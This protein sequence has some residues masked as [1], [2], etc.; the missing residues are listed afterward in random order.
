M[1]HAFAA[2]RGGDHDLAFHGGALYLGFKAPLDGGRAAIWKVADPDKLLAGDAA[3]A[4]IALF[5]HVTLP[6]QMGIADM[7]FV[8]DT[9]LVVSGTT[10]SGSGGVFLVALGKGEPSVTPLQMFP[11]LRPEGVALSPLGKLAVVFDR[12]KSVPLWTELELPHASM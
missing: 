7:M 12:G 10:Q 5:T 2:L 3:G 6:E 9:S 4:G 8:N 11:G 1:A